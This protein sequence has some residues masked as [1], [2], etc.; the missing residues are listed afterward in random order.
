M[1]ELLKGAVGQEEEARSVA[2][3]VLSTE[4]KY[5]FVYFGLLIVKL[6]LDLSFVLEMIIGSI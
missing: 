5:L 2:L 1:P 3:E 4:L 6:S